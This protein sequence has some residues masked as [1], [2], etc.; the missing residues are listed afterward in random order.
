MTD[1][2]NSKLTRRSALTAAT[3]LSS[4]AALGTAAAPR[5][6][7]A[8]VDNDISVAPD[9]KYERTEL[10][11]DVIK[12]IAIQSQLIGVDLGQPT[13]TDAQES[14]QDDRADR[15]RQWLHSG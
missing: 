2:T 3:A 12:V 6:A 9:G 14:R 8:Q 11:K 10:K 7:Q 1:Q 5:E 4:A 15:L 13:A